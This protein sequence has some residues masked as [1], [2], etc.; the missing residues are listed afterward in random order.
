MYLINY[1]YIYN[2]QKIYSNRDVL[3]VYL[4]ASQQQY[5]MHHYL[6]YDYNL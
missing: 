2:I 4:I 5:H 3:C 6:Q 1:K